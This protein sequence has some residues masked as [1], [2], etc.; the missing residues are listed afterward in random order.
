MDLKRITLSEKSRPLKVTYCMI[1]LIQHASKMKLQRWRKKT[2]V[3]LGTWRGAG[4][5]RKEG[6]CAYKIIV[7]WILVMETVLCLDGGRD[8]RHLHRRQNCT[9]QNPHVQMNGCVEN[10]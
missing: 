7:G 2:V 5:E 3:V 8:H 9:E 4:V 1:P 6:G 10:W